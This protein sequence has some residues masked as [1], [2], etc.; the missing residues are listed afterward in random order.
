MKA[1]VFGLE[2]GCTEIK[3]Y[4]DDQGNQDLD[5][6]KEGIDGPVLDM[7]LSAAKEMDGE[8]AEEMGEKEEEFVEEFEDGHPLFGLEKRMRL[9]KIDDEMKAVI[10]QKLVEQHTKV[11]A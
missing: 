5:D 9:A 8:P 4:L 7:E 3:D 1:P 2:D 10:K 6:S 11:L